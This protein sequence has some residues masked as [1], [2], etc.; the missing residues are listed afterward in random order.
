MLTATNERTTTYTYTDNF[1]VDI[2]E[3][4]TKY[5]AWIYHEKY[6]I[7]SLMFGMPKEQQPLSD[8]LEIVDGSM[9]EYIDEYT[10][11]YMQEA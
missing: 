1:K 10:N 4:D 7:K 6:G 8:F 3:N 9:E 5:E 11:D 2:L